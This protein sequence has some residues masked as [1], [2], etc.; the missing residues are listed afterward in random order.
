MKNRLEILQR[1]LESFDEELILSPKT[2]CFN[3][4]TF[5]RHSATN[6]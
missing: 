2:G 4:H 5:Y 3:C 6:S 1:D